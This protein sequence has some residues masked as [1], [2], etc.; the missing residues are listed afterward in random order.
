MK[1]LRVECLTIET[2][3]E[4]PIV[5]KDLVEAWRWSTWVSLLTCPM[6]SA[7]AMYGKKWDEMPPEVEEFVASNS[8][9]RQGLNEG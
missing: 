2:Y 4:L 3:S 1:S 5:L 8:I 9:D 7:E 6:K